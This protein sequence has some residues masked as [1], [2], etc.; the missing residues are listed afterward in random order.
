M[1]LNAGCGDDMRGDIRVD[2]KPTRATTHVANIE[3]LS[4]IPDN[5]VDD[6]ICISVLEH[7]DNPVRAI[8]ELCRVTK[9]RIIIEVP[10]NSRQGFSN[11]FRIFVP[12]RENLYVLRN[13]PKHAREDKW[14]FGK[15]GIKKLLEKNG[16][17][18]V[19]NRKCVILWAHSISR[20]YRTVGI[21]NE[22]CI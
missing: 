19:V 14:N 20:C 8:K 2:I 22:N 21:K 1:I 6:T 10:V 13:L 5:S 3:D 18:V 9:R 7:T 4:F 17:D 12:T 11:I 15:D 16:F